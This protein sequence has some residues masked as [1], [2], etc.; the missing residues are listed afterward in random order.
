M[1]LS[2]SMRLLLYIGGIRAAGMIWVIGTRAGCGCVCGRGDGCGCGYVSLERGNGG[3][4]RASGL[5]SDK[6]ARRLAWGVGV[7]CGVCLV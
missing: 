6:G 5:A 7:G 2:L 3:T 1:I 4:G